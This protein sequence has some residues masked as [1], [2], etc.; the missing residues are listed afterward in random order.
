M[1]KLNILIKENKMT[2][3]IELNK[4]VC[5]KDIKNKLR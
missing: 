5:K 4:A 2:Y 3:K 1:V